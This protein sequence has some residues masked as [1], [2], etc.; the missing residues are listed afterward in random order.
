MFKISYRTAFFI[1]LPTIIPLILF[2]LDF[3]GPK[4]DVKSFVQQK[5]LYK[6]RHEISFNRL[7]DVTSLSQEDYYY[8]RLHDSANIKM[9]TFLNTVY[10]FTLIKQN[11]IIR[12]RDYI[13]ILLISCFSSVSFILGF[14]GVFK[15]FTNG[16]YIERK[17]LSAY[18]A[19][20]LTGYCATIIYLA[21]R[22][23]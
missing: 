21:C 7:P 17:N 5:W 18:F 10:Q 23:L 4:K 3:F 9:G 13:Y 1:S 11:K 16:V 14:L 12:C 19:F 2:C 20:W 8:I 15:K 22:N 6:G